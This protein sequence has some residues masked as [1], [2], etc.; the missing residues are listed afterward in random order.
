MNKHHEY[1]VL[2]DQLLELAVLMEE[3][4]A[5]DLGERGLSRARVHVLWLV[6]HNGPQTQRG[7][8]EAIGSSPRNVTG[9]VDGLEATG[10]VTRETHP[11]DRRALLVTLTTHGTAVAEELQRGHQTLARKLFEGLPARR[12]AE[13]GAGLAHVLDALRT[14]PAPADP[15]DQVS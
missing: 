14:V 7:L 1:G 2:L 13:L 15:P 6:H 11:S 4:M 9:L 3:D 12:R 8:A 10:F 5:R